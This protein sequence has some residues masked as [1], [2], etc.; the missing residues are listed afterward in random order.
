M[1]P[2]YSS[3]A[4]LCVASLL[5]SPSSA[6]VS[7]A[8][9]AGARQTS[10]APGEVGEAGAPW[11]DARGVSVV[12]G[13]TF[14]FGP[15]YTVELDDRGMTY[16]PAFGPGSPRAH[17]LSFE[18]LDVRRGA[19]RVHAAT[20]TAPAVAGDS[21]AF[22]RGSIVERYEMRADGVHQT[23]LFQEPLPGR[24]DLVVR[25][26]VDTSFAGAFAAP[27]GGIAFEQPGIGVVEYG[28]V[29]GIDAAGR[30][31]AGE[32][33]LVGD[34]LELVLPAS[35]VDDAAYPLLLD[36]LVGTTV[37][38]SGTGA[39]SSPAVAYDVTND[40]Y[41]VAWD[42][43]PG[44]GLHEL[45]GALVSAATGA[46]VASSLI[47]MNNTLEYQASVGN[48]NASDRF[49]LAYHSN[50]GGVPFAEVRAYAVSAVT[51]AQ[52]GGLTVIG[53][54]N[55]AHSRPDVGGV[56]NGSNDAALVVWKE[57]GFGL[58][59]AQVTVETTGAPILD[60]TFTVTSDPGDDNPAVSHAAGA[61]G[62][63]YA[64]V[65]ERAG[66][67]W[68]RAIDSDGNELAPER[69]IT[70]PLGFNVKAR[71]DVDGDGTDFVV[72][73]EREESLASPFR[74]VYAAPV[75]LAGGLL[76]VGTVVAIEANADD[77]ERNPAVAFAGDK[78]FVAYV[79][80]DGTDN[81]Y[82]KGVATLTAEVCEVGMALNTPAEDRAPALA[83]EWAGGS[84]A[85]DGLYV[86]WRGDEILGQRL[87]AFGG[88]VVTDLGGGCA[89]GGTMDSKGPAAVGN[90]DFTLGLTG[91]GGSLALLSISLPTLPFICG[92]CETIVLGSFLDVP[93]PIAGG[94]ASLPVPI[95]FDSALAGV[96]VHAQWT[97]LGIA[98]SPCALFPNVASSNR[99][100]IGIEY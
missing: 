97:A 32:L 75:T 40:V 2:S 30:E 34:E 7:D 72:A 31:A 65:W 21:V 61:L 8:P 79:D 15:G 13:R 23:F 47:G 37:T 41:F 33:R 87:E 96:Q 16:S 35:L 63:P 99:L 36:P 27:G 58:R 85:G 18:L 57:D 84:S 46:V 26:R 91:S 56:R 24:G 90:Q 60:A 43:E 11:R 68:G 67:I 59:G 44:G 66:D 62:S 22:A 19:E 95:P 17:H 12:D 92:S 1:H 6:Q 4:L 73:W 78:S 98:T 86:A 3:L 5:A 29:L 88:G 89:D 80:T 49:L 100:E 38:L 69:Q 94:K 83:S 55:S 54:G 52:S 42:H 71:P 20:P 77:D 93:A 9:E 14:G 82:V 45:R 28:A 64:V 25:G 76:S 53:T 50:A 10:A 70:L 51:G 74:D 48:V 81:V 39:V